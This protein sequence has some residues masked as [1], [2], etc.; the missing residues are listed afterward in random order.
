MDMRYNS[1]DYW[2]FLA[3]YAGRRIVRGFLLLIGISF[4]CFLLLQLSPGDFFVEARLNPQLSPSTLAALRAQHALDRPLLLKY[5]YWVGSV[6]RGDGGFSF[7]YNR[8]A[9]DLLS[10]RTANTLLLTIMAN[11]VAWLIA[12]PLALWSAAATSRFVE[13]F[14]GGCVSLLLALPD[15]L[16]VLLL[17]FAAAHTR[18]FPLGGMTSVQY[19]QL[20]GWTKFSDRLSHLALPVAA[21]ALSMLPPLLEQARSSVSE[22]L[23]STFIRA[24]RAH[25]IPRGRLLLRHAL[26][27]AANPLISLLGLSLGTLLSSSLLVEAAFGWPGIGQLLLQAT[28]A[29]DFYVV[30]DAVMLSAAFLIAGNFLADVLQRVMDPR[31]RPE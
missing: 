16:I 3:A 8:P 26:P 20:G 2:Q 24:A 23:G 30:I 17:L 28:L 13:L 19:S 15:L 11:T 10:E 4:L 21:L 9:S 29:R 22:V 5:S 7:A 1:A 25:G 27:A 14:V 12:I 31:I 18:L 6:F